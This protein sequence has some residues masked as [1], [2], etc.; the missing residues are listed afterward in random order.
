MAEWASAGLDGAVL[1]AQHCGHHKLARVASTLGTQ[2][3]V[4]LFEP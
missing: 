1:A 3:A 4:M 2:P